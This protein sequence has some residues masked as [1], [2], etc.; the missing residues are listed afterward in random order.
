MKKLHLLLLGFF[1]LMFTSIQAQMSNVALASRYEINDSA[2]GSV[3]LEF[4]NQNFLR[5]NEYFHDH[6]TGYTLFG[7]LLQTKLS[8][9]PSERWKLTT[10]IFLRRDFGSNGFYQ[11][12]PM[13]ILK[14]QHKGISFVVGNLEGNFNHRLLEPLYNYERFLTNNQETGLQFRVDRKKIWSDTWINWEVMQYNRSNYQEQFSA[15]NHT[16]ITLLQHAKHEL[17]VI[18][19][20]LIAHKGGQ[21]DIDTSAMASKLSTAVGLEYVWH[22]SSFIKEIKT[23]HYLLYSSFLNAAK[24]DPYHQGNAYYATIGLNTKYDVGFNMSFW[25]GNRFQTSHGGDLFQS[26]S[27]DYTQRRTSDNNRSLLFVRLFYQK[28]LAK[29]IYMDIRFEPYYDLNHSFLEYAYSFY[30]TYKKDFVLFNEK[31]H[32]KK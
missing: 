4:D 9:Q 14:Y 21:I 16:Q 6:A 22:T 31:N 25:Q 19:Q 12:Q 24:N 18:A 10:G 8:Y 5:N 27:S 7:T 15:G 29:D 20:G 3:K 26:L 32:P 30:L 1:T 13:L 28:K 17:K 2:A 11:V 23:Q